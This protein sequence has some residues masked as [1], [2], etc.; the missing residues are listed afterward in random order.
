MPTV[1]VAVLFFGCCTLISTAPSLPV[2]ALCKAEGGT[3]V[4]PGTCLGW[5]ENLDT[6]C[7]T[8]VCCKSAPSTVNPEPARPNNGTCGLITRVE[9]PTSA[10]VQR[11]VGG[12]DA[13]EGEWPWQVAF[14]DMRGDL[15]C[16]GVLISDQFVVTAAHCFFD[17]SEA[18]T[19]IVLGEHHLAHHTGNEVRRT[20]KTIVKHGDYNPVTY[21]N[22][23]AF[24]QLNSPV[25]ITG[26]Y[27]RTACLGTRDI[28]W[29]SADACFASGWGYTQDYIT[30]SRHLQHVPMQLVNTST[31]S[32]AWR[33]YATVS[34][35]QNV[36]AGNGTHG[37]CQGDSGGPLVCYRDGQYHVVG[38]TSFGYYTCTTAGYPDVYMR[39]SAYLDWMISYMFLLTSTA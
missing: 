36:C 30:D 29:T 2:G 39:I 20:A 7:K 38:V 22:D 37:T 15:F 17:Q 8:D 1:F 16:G 12:L 26:H 27:V 21:E 24:V 9:R 31:C 19:Q 5:V 13:V 34:D 25:D 18:D 28:T 11:I 3:C 33:S 35:V 6:S 14:L 32:A 10:H 4:K 23:I